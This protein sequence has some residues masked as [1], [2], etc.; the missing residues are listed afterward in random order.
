MSIVT[1][2]GDKGETGLFGGQRVAK[3]DV[4]METI[5]TVDELNAF[6]SLPTDEDDLFLSVIEQIGR[7]QN[8]LFTLGADLATPPENN[9][10]V[11]PRIEEQHIMK[12]EEWIDMMEETPLPPYFVL[13][14]GS[15]AAAFLHAS[16]AICRRAERHAVS[17]SQRTDI[18]MHILKYLNRLSDFL[19]LA[20][21]EANRGAKLEN[22]RVSYQ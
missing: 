7:I 19:F 1:R 17:L 21:L 12:L 2:T 6:L 22:I 3:D 10:A 14:G 9:L 8:Q 13:P 4:R 18:G 5:G 20:A 16:R 11:V 15:R